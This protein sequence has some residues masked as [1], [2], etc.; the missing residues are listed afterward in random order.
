MKNQFKI[1]LSTTL[2]SS[3]RAAPKAHT[4]NKFT[5]PSII[6]S[7]AHVNSK[8]KN[9]DNVRF[10]KV[11]KLPIVREHLIPTLHADIAISETTL[12]KNIKNNDF[13]NPSLLNKIKVLN[14]L[15]K[16]TLQPQHILILYLQ[17][18][19]IDVMYAQYVK[20]RIMKLILTSYQN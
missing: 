7:T 19:E 10:C 16:I 18:T 14:Q 9:L 20:I 4:D 5:D 1:K 3:H 8:D 13:I 12:A 11:N 6:E 2:T 15:I 17:T